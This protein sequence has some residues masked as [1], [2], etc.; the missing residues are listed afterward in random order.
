MGGEARLARR[1]WREA[2]SPNGRCAKRP[3][4]GRSLRG[5]RHDAF[6]VRSPAPP[7]VAVISFID[8]INR[9]DLVGLTNHMEEHHT[10]MVHGEEPLVGRDANTEAWNGYFAAFPNYVIYP[11]RIATYGERVAVLGSTTGSHLLLPDDEE[12]AL[13]VIWTATVKD[14]RLAEWRIRDDTAETRSELG[15]PD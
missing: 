9:G 8:C 12:L 11:R 13:T 1:G 5:V 7:V 15:L 10:L 2:S 3:Q 14:G 4:A 6:V